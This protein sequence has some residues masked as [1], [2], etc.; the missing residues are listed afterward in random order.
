MTY[1]VF[2]G[3]SNPTQSTQSI[4]FA[5]KITLQCSRLER[6]AYRPLS[7]VA[8]S[9]HLDSGNVWQTQR[10]TCFPAWSL[11]TLFC[12]TQMYTLLLITHFCVHLQLKK[13]RFIR[14]LLFHLVF[15]TLLGFVMFLI[16]CPSL[17]LIT[18]RSYASAVYIGWRWRKFFISAVFRHF[19]G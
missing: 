14:K 9:G 17:P 18:P 10:H 5:Q 7:C 3:T 12:A 6:S 8:D 4:D 11:R 16:P 1:N 2:S 13:T 15:Y 19:V